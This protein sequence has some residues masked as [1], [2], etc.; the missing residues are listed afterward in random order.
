[1]LTFHG[2]EKQKDDETSPREKRYKKGPK[3]AL[4]DRIN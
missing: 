4:A 1:M 3:I 2:E